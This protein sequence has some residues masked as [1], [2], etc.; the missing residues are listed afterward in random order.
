MATINVELDVD[1][2]T[3]GIAQFRKSL[4]KFSEDLEA[5]RDEPKKDQPKKEEFVTVTDGWRGSLKLKECWIDGVHLTEGNSIELIARWNSLF[6]YFNNGGIR[7]TRNFKFRP[8][9]PDRPPSVD[10]PLETDGGVRYFSGYSEGELMFF[11]DGETSL[12]KGDVFPSRITDK[13]E[14]LNIEPVEG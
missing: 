13:L 8:F 1:G 5:L 3:E 10:W 11:C 6:C 4:K 2:I 12:Q 7:Y 14:F 9:S